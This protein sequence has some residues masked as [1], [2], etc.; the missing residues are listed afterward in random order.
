[1][2][3]ESRLRLNQV[4]AYNTKAQSA[5]NSSMP[6][7]GGCGRTFETFDKL[8][9]HSAGC[10][11]K[12]GVAGGGAGRRGRRGPDSGGLG[13]GGEAGGGGEVSSGNG[14]SSMGGGDGGGGGGVFG[15]KGG[16]RML[17]CYLCGTSHGL[18]SLEIHQKQCA[19]KRV[20]VQ[21]T[22]DPG[23][24]TAEPAPP[25]CEIPGLK[26]TMSQVAV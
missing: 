8:A 6:A 26:A 20:K 3:T 25:D 2:S 7:C 12:K 24:R 5:Y 21:Q 18:S 1:M 11:E 19:E 15:S 16:P 9:A 10:K 14:S 22:L 13:G 23:L 17:V 4:E